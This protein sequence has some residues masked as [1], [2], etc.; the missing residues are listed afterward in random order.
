MARAVWFAIEVLERKGYHTLGHADFVKNGKPEN[1]KADLASKL[2]NMTIN[3][4]KI[5]NSKVNSMV[6]AHEY[7]K[8]AIILIVVYSMTLAITFPIMR[9]ISVGTNDDKVIKILSSTNTGT[10]ILLACF[11]AIIVNIIFIRKSR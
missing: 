5:I 3:N 6:L 2:I 9:Y 7:F 1:Y 11:I 8:R 4:Q 10:W